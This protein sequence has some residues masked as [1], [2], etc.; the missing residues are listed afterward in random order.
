MSMATWS[1]PGGRLILQTDET[2]N[3][4]DK[5]ITV[6][7]GKRWLILW[8]HVEYT[9]SATAGARFIEMHLRDSSDNIIAVATHTININAGESYNLE[10]LPSGTARNGSTVVNA[11]IP[12]PPITILEAGYDIRIFDSAAIDPAADNMIIKMLVL[13][14]SKP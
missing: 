8:C 10:F 13:E 1:F 9:A 2:A 7:T 4:S 3:D 14:C 5:T 6:P 11:I 12:L